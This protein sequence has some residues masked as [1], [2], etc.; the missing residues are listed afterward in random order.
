MGLRGTVDR[1]DIPDVTEI[2]EL[3]QKGRSYSVAVPFLAGLEELTRTASEDPFQWDTRR[4]RKALAF[5]FCTPYDGTSPNWYLSLVRN[6]PETVADVLVQFAGSG[7]RSDRN[8]IKRLYEFAH[9]P[10]HAEVARH[11]SLA[12]L[13]A[14]PIRCRVRHLPFVENLLWA[15]LQH[16]ERPI[17]GRLIERKLSCSSMNVAQ[18]V[19]WLAAGL[20]VSPVVYKDRLE[21]FVKGSEGRIRRMADFHSSGLRVQFSFDHLEVP[22]LEF[23]IRLAVSYTHLTLPTKRIV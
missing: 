1:D 11:A 16:S 2:F 5:Y 17:L 6:R 3:D 4:I 22:V 23:L 18:R 20:T 14:V 7:F 10:E 8:H 19:Y 13:R 21:N 12:L 15:A 9:D